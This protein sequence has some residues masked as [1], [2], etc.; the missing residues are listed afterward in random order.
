MV[1]TFVSQ[2][3]E[4]CGGYQVASFSQE[5]TTHTHRTGKDSIPQED[6]GE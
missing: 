1:P 4:S 5:V 3:V 6:V 2:L